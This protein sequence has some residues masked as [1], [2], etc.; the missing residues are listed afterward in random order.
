MFFTIYTLNANMFFLWRNLFG[1]NIH[2]HTHIHFIRRWKWEAKNLFWTHT[3]LKLKFFSKLW[4]VRVILHDR[5]LPPPPAAAA[6]ISVDWWHTK[7]VPVCPVFENAS[8]NKRI[9]F[10]LFNFSIEHQNGIRQ[11][12]N[13]HWEI[14]EITI[15]LCFFVIV[16]F[17]FF[18]TSPFIKVMFCFLYAMGNSWRMQLKSFHSIQIV[19]GTS[20]RW[21]WFRW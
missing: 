3:Y 21:I 13:F 12:F 17:F 4:W 14:A 1:K 11:H 10:P 7:S 9:I 19:D 2:T 18:I 15:R 8:E 20:V 16:F 6:N 5:F